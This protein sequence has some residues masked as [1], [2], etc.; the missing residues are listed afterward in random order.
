VRDRA[1]R[2]CWPTAVFVVVAILAVVAARAAGADPAAVAEAG[3]LAALQLWFLPVYPLLI[4]LTPV[5]LTVR[6]RWGLAVPAGM[7]AAA[8]VPGSKHRTGQRCAMGTGS[9]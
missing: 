5:M 6:R 3:W 9:Q 7:A 4:A 2:L 8:R 1:T